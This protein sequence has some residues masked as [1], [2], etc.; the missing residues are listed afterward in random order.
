MTF[1]LLITICSTPKYNYV[2]E[3]AVFSIPEL[4]Q[5]VSSG[6]GELLLDQGTSTKRDVLYIDKET[7]LAAYKVVTGKLFK[8]GEDSKYVSTSLKM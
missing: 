8:S 6:L 3:R 1:T 5:Q 2:P 4:N 7:G